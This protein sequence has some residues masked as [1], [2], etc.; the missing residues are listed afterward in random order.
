[1]K[2]VEIDTTDLYIVGSPRALA[3]NLLIKIL[4]Y[5]ELLDKVV[6]LVN[7]DPDAGVDVVVND[8]DVSIE[9]IRR[10]S[11]VE[12]LEKVKKLGKAV[13]VRLKDGVEVAEA[14]LKLD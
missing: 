3:Y 5:Y 8:L 4:G 12:E 13:V 7:R 11:R 14:V 1:M 10:T 9:E 6:L 2:V